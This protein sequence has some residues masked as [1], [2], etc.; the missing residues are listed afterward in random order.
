MNKRLNKVYFNTQHTTMK[1]FTNTYLKSRK[2]ALGY[3]SIT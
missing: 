1:K 2:F 3:Q